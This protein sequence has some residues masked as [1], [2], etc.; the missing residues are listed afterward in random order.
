MKSGI[1]VCSKSL[2]CLDKV[3]QTGLLKTTE[4][5]GL[6]VLEAG[7]YVPVELCFPWNWLPCRF[8][9]STADGWQC[10]A[11]PCL[12]VTPLQSLLLLSRDILR[13]SLSKFSS[14]CKNNSHVRSQPTLMNPSRLHVKKPYFQIRSHSQV[15]GAKTSTYLSG[16]QNL[17]HSIFLT[18]ISL[19]TR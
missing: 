10:W 9:T 14:S 16:K 11:M 5:D 17:T 1:T 2:G 13:V 12:A 4:V 15:L 18:Y 8:L 19:I 6:T 3:P 7:V